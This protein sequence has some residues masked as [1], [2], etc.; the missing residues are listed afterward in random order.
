LF[1][2]AEMRHA[3]PETLDELE[4]VLEE[5]RALPGLT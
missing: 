5:I 4:A 1:G 2:G 3:R